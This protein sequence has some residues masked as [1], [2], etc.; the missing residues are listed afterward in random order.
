[1]SRPLDGRSCA[2]PTST[3]CTKIFF[4]RSIDTRRIRRKKNWMNSSHSVTRDVRLS[5]PK[6]S[7]KAI[8]IWFRFRGAWARAENDWKRN[9]YVNQVNY[10]VDLYLS[11]WP[12]NGNV[13]LHGVL[14]DFGQ[15]TNKFR[16]W[17]RSLLNAPLVFVLSQQDSD[18]DDLP[19]D[20]STF[21]VE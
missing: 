20:I 19:H 21:V 2:G 6:I 8:Q 5:C 15:Q 11:T 18:I 12:A 14:E 10:H 1:M 3:N 17:F 9:I 4:C 16:F 7:Q 13:K